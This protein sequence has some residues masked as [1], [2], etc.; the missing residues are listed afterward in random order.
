MVV[1]AML[2]G[3]M[4]YILVL[5]LIQVLKIPLD[6]L[7]MSFALWNFAVTGLISVFWKG[8][9][10]LQQVYL[11]VMSSLMVSRFSMMC[12]RPEHS[13][14]SAPRTTIDLN[15]IFVL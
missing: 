14:N 12:C 2:L 7:T 4:G 15:D 8:P 10:W 1:V 11:T 13:K 3:F 5:N 6:F 9:M